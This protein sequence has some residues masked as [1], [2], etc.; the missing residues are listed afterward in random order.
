M[1]APHQQDV[2]DDKE[3]GGRAFKLNDAIPLGGRFRAAA[4][5]NEHATNTLHELIAAIS[6]ELRLKGLALTVS[7]PF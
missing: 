3:P 1:L 5:Q 7:E 4:L 2:L 6:E